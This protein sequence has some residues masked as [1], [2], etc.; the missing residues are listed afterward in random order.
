MSDK[1]MISK[2]FASLKAPD[3]TLERIEEKMNHVSNQKGTL[4]HRRLTLVLA[5]LLVLALGTAGAYAVKSFRLGNVLPAAGNIVNADGLVVKQ[6]EAEDELK[7]FAISA[8]FAEQNPHTGF[9]HDGI[10]FMA[11]EGTP[12]LAAA[13]GQ[14]VTAKFDAQEGNHVVIDHGNGYT[15][16][17]SHMKDL[18]V[19]TGDVIEA[20]TE[21]GSVG[22]TGQSTGPHLHLQLLK[23]GTPVDPADCWAE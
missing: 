4:R 15:T 20:G 21:I 6:Q 5:A 17:Y 2:A 1:E 22:N 13:P 19:A 23:D 16:V 7:S 11:D 3:D 18:K 8:P 14:V 9:V 10:D 12:V